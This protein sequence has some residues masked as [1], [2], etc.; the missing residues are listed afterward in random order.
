MLTCVPVANLLN[1][2]NSFIQQGPLYQYGTA[3][4]LLVI[5]NQE[6]TV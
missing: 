4:L 1:L 3:G 6:S 5:W 2:H